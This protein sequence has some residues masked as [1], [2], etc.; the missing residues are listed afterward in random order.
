LINKGVPGLAEQ[1]FPD[2]GEQKYPRR[3][4]DGAGSN[5]ISAVTEASCP[6][7]RSARLRAV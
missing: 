2:D 6:G 7:R 1:P 3:H 5:I 4:Q